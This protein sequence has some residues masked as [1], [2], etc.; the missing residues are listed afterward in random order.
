MIHFDWLEKNK[1]S[2]DPFFYWRLRVFWSFGYWGYVCNFI[3]R[4]FLCFSEN[5]YF[6]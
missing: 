5:H 4:L 6:Y 3:R 2:H 1:L